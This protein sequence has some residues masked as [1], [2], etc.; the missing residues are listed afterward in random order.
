MV[1][2]D[3]DEGEAVAAIGG[4]ALAA[5]VRAEQQQ[6]VD[7]LTQ[8][9]GLG[10]AKQD[11]ISELE[12]LGARQRDRRLDLTCAL[13]GQQAGARRQV[14]PGQAIQPPPKQV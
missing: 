14:W 12:G 8:L 4:H 2:G 7:V 9:A 10:V 5:A 13:G 3:S 11:G 1:A 6:L